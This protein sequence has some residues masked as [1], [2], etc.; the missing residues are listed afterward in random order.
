[1][2][3][4]FHEVFTSSTTH[5]V[6]STVCRY[7][8]RNART[9][10]AV[11]RPTRRRS[12]SVQPA[13][14]VSR[15]RLNR[16]QEPTRRR[17]PSTLVPGRKVTAS[18]SLNST[19]PTRTPTPTGTSSPTSARGSSRGCRRVRSAGHTS[20]TRT[21]ILADLSDTRAFPPR[22]SV[23][24]ARVYTCTVH[25]KLSCRPTRLQNY[26]IGA[27]LM[28]VSVWVPWNSSFTRQ[29]RHSSTVD[30]GRPAVWTESSE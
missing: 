7:V 3:A 23:R 4:K 8:C 5:T 15:Q 27:S 20:R 9:S 29:T 18:L 16:G 30:G 1:M 28:S 24:D 21:T 17:P 13:P 12:H 19:G 10:C 22:M 2:R 26:T 11:W 14:P 25:D 6:E